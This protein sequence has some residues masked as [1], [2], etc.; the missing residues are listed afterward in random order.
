VLEP[1]GTTGRTVEVGAKDVIIGRDA[2]A[3]AVVIDDPSVAPRHAR[4]VRM[5]DGTPWVFDL[6]SAAGS[7]RNFEEV[8]PEGAALREGDRLNFGR[9]AFR[10]RLRPC[11]P[12]EENIE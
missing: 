6:G 9:A 10:V 5:G 7:W 2:Q 11:V 12:A 3:A 8:P 1:I 4:I